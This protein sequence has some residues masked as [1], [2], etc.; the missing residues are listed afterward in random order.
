M[1]KIK[2]IVNK[3]VLSCSNMFLVFLLQLPV[4]PFFLRVYM[5]KGRAL[6]EQLFTQ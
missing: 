6:E 5:P 3:S 1:I 4:R 2:K